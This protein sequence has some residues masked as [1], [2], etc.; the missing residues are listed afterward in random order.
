M[1][2]FVMQKQFLYMRKLSGSVR[3]DSMEGR[4][5]RAAFKNVQSRKSKRDSNNPED[6]NFI[7]MAT[8]Q[9]N[10]LHWH[11]DIFVRMGKS[12]LYHTYFVFWLFLAENRTCCEN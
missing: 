7:T 5:C 2:S 6:L 1:A 12:I 10:Q 11:S 9:W 4:R 3:T 8:T